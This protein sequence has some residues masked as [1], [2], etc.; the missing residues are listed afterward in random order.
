MKIDDY[1]VL[2]G[3]IGLILSPIISL[4]GVLLSERRQKKRD[5]D[6]AL[7]EQKEADAKENE[8][9]LLMNKAAGEALSSYGTIIESLRKQGELNSNQ[10]Q[11]LKNELKLVTAEKERLAQEN[12]KLLEHVKKQD[13][14]IH[15]QSLEIAELRHK[16][17]ALENK[18]E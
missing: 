8:L 3:F 2:F 1:A 18:K 4:I 6:I 5:A 9:Q 17:S 13:D 7:K 15:E 12:T 16:I 10:I 11:V 14:K